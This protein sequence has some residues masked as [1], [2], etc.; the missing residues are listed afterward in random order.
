MPA[1]PILFDTD[2]GDDIDDALA[3]A[4]ACNSP[5]LSLVGIT[6]VFR[7]APRRA[8]LSREVLR[9]LGRDDVPIVA[10]CSEPLLPDWENFPEGRQLGRQFE[11]LDPALTWTDP[12]HAVNFIIRQV[13]EHSERGNPLTL[14][15]IGA[16]TNIALAFR[17]APD[18]ISQCRV[19]MMGGMW[20]RA[21]PEWNFRCDP[22]AAAIVFSSRAVLSMVGLDVT[23]QCVLS[24]EQEEL[25]HQSEHEHARF[26]G[27]LITLWNHRVTLHDPLTI[28]TLFS[29]V[30]EFEPKRI[31]IGLHGDVRAHSE[32]VE[33]VPNASV[34]VKVD[35]A[36]VT[37]LFLDRALRLS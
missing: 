23:N 2:I 19:V 11:A 32:P 3:L 30:V 6:T 7:D 33:G 29:D 5:E 1:T 22:E 4:V 26:L 31:K 12:E 25:F 34:A 28:L 10:G 18:I 13:R 17:L 16:L 21:H 35:V 9:L 36:R 14:V 27:R 8:I 20:S 37:R 15:P 24:K